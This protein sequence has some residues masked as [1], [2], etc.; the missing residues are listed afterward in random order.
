MKTG[1]L[2]TQ[3]SPQLDKP[4]WYRKLN[5]RLTVL[6]AIVSILLGVAGLLGTSP[7]PWWGLVLFWLSVWITGASLVAAAIS[8]LH[9]ELDA[10][11]HTIGKNESID[12]D[13]TEKL[14]H[15]GT[16]LS[17]LNESFKNAIFAEHIGNDEAAVAYLYGQYA[18]PSLCKVRDVMVRTDEH[19]KLYGDS[20]YDRLRQGMEVLMGR[21]NTVVMEIV[22]PRVDSRIVRQYVDAMDKLGIPRETQDHKV[23]C[24]R[25]RTSGPM[26]NFVILDHDNGSEVLAGWAH[27][28]GW[29]G[30]VWRS[31][32]SKVV[33]EFHAFYESLLVKSNRVSLQSLLDQGPSAAIC[34][35]DDSVE[36]KPSLES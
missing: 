3:P 26:M 30:A 4:A 11:R 12:A 9:S 24:H 25:L 32:N 5:F 28:P 10:I 34:T 7:P 29:P 22:G 33:E 17:T 35:V 13:V 23:Q 1:T 16:I 2:V 15:V 27:A 18:L 31:R 20:T 14:N 21:P 8:Q 36:H 6:F 19:F